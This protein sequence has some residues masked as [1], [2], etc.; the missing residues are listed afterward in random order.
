[1][2]MLLAS[3]QQIDENTVEFETLTADKTVFLTQEE[4]SPACRAYSLRIICSSTRFFLEHFSADYV[5]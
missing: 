3:C 2:V 4:N 5:T 1:M